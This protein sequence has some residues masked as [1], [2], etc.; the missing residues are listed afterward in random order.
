MN[1]KN[2]R[3]KISLRLFTNEKDMWYQKGFKELELKDF[4][5]IVHLRLETLVVE[6]TRIYNDLADVD[7]RAI[8]LL[9]KDEQ[10]NLD[11]Y[12]RIFERGQTVH[13][14]RVAVA[15]DSRG[16]GLG[17]ENLRSLR[18]EVSRSDH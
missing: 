18:A 9:R 17:R 16:K 13:F 4:Y 14:G 6:Q 15:K 10:G 12:A 11:G 3:E 7:F 2:R 1:M 5:Q 8:H